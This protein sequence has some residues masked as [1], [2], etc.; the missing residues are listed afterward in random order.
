MKAWFHPEARVEFLESV[1]YYEAQAAGLGHRFLE[2]V[3]EAIHQIQD[4]PN[5]YPRVSHEWRQC[6][7]PRF[8]YGIIFRVTA[9][10]IEIHAVMHLHRR[11]GYWKDRIAEQ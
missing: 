9:R 1:A 7:I 10:R 8:P 2:G 11:P 3:T 6:R 5:L 4:R